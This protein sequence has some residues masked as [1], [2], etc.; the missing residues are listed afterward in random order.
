MIE[1]PKS[2]MTLIV[3]TVTRLTTGLVLLFGIYIVFHGHISA[4]GG[5]AGGVIIGLSFIHLMLAYGKEITTKKLSEKA[6]ELL[7]N[8]G[9]IIFIVIAVLGLFSGGYFFFDSMNKGKPFDLFS[10]GAMP[11]YNVAISLII[12][13]GLFTIFIAMVFFRSNKK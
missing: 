5:F 9:A 8:L 12:G 7:G 2:G 11:L 4:E 6:G 10:A 13:A 1:K 3:R